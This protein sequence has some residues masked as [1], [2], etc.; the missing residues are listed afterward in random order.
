MGHDRQNVGA[1]EDDVQRIR[2]VWAGLDTRK[3]VIIVAAG[4]AMFVAF[5]AMSRMAATPNMRL[6]FAGLESSSA[7]EVVRSLEQRGTPYEVRGGSILVPAAQRDELRM[8]LASEGL[9]TN[10]GRGYELLDSLNGF[11]TTSQMFDTAY[12]RAKEGE[13]AR[14]IVASNHISQARVHIAKT[15]S[16]PFQRDI[17]PTASV[18]VVPAGA[19][20]TPAQANAIR[21]LVASAV[22]GLSVANVAVID[23]NG[24]LIGSPETA[25]SSSTADDRAQQMRDRVLRLVEARVGSGNAVVEIS[26]ETVTKTESIRERR[27]DPNSRVAISTEIEERSDSSS[28]HQGAADVT[29]ASNLPDG[30]AASGDGS[31]AKT[32]STVERI[33][34]EV[35][36]T[37]LEILRSPGAV[38]RLTVAVLV[39]GV[40]GPDPDGEAVFQQRPEDELAALRELVASAVGFDSERG[41]VITLK[42]MDLPAIETLGTMAGASF[43]Q[44]LNLDT[45]SLIQMAALAIVTLVLGLF[46]VKPILSNTSALPVSS[47]AVLPA[48]TPGSSSE[49]PLETQVLTG[50][51]DDGSSAA[52]GSL[53]PPSAEGSSGSAGNIPALIDAPVDPANRLRSMIGERQEETVEILRSW[54]EESEETV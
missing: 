28:N 18:S 4:L 21:H 24:S 19:P 34:Y 52:F 5:L 25:S 38:K 13:L 23:A 44:Q 7:G 10:G 49:L 16:N 33:N 12:W 14:T 27:F 35:S 15:G 11:G 2:I 17:K 40:T 41:D 46:V 29:I 1:T 53:A 39:N 51:L 48:A 20:V 47:L 30:D 8:I 9:P 50:E 3:Q 54:L 42:S 22:S 37:E 31:N 43:F 26:L 45:M 36:E 6:L 32:S